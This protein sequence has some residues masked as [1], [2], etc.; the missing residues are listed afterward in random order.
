M[1][2]IYIKE[3]EALL[4]ANEDVLIGPLSLGLN[5]GASYITGRRSATVFSSVNQASPQGVQSVK[6]NLASSTEW[7]D[8]ASVILSFDVVNDDA[9]QDLYPATVGAH[10]LFERYQCRIA[11]S[12]IED[13]EHYGRTVEAFTRLIPAEKRLNDGALG[14]GTVITT[15]A[16]AATD[17]ANPP[18]P[19]TT[20][21]HACTARAVSGG[22][23]VTSAHS[24]KP[25]GHTAG[26]DNRR[27]VFMKLPLSGVFTSNQKYLP[28]WA[29][30]AGGVEITLSLA[31]AAQ[32]VIPTGVAPA[33]SSTY[34]LED[35]RL[36]VDMISMDSS[37]QEKYSRNMLEGGSLLL[38]T[39][40]W[41]CTQVYFPPQMQE[42]LM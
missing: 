37:L 3:M 24:A 29:L 4:S 9:A 41:N 23:F 38:H 39:K 11:S 35:M 10:C 19:P 32:A 8:P 2:I 16:A 6:W 22:A 33:K 40:L 28:L 27:R 25:I 30:G 18:G 12:Q 31:P 36:E 15:T 5:E 13:I 42:A 7:A 26:V 1:N 21:A 17:G 20:T 14:F 34:H